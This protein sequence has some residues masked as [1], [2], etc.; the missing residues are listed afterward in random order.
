[1]KTIKYLATAILLCLTIAVSAQQNNTRTAY[2]LDGYTYGYRLNPAFA[3]KHNFVSIPVLGNVSLGAESNLA[4]SDFLYPSSNGKLALFIDD[5][6]S[7]QDFLGGLKDENKLNSNLNLTLLAVGFKTGNLY[8]TVDLS[9]KAGQNALLPKSLFSFVK[10]GTE[11]GDQSWNIGNTGIGLNAYG[12]LAYGLSTSIGESLRVGGRLKVILGLARAQMMIDQLDI[13]MSQE[14]W[15]ASTNG[16]IEYSG[17]VRFAVEGNNINLSSV[18]FGPF[19]GMSGFGLGVDLG[20]SYDF[21]DMFTA[22]VSLLDLGFTSWK[23]TTF[24][25]GGSSYEFD[26]FG[27]ISSGDELKDQLNGMTDELMDI[28]QFNK[29]GEGSASKG[30]SATLHAGLEARMPFYDRL[31]FGALA[32]HRFNGAYSWTEGRLAANVNPID[33]IGIAASYGISNFGSSLGG[34]VN[35]VFPGFNF[36]V[37]VDSFIPLMNVTPQFIPI[38]NLNTSLALGFNITFGK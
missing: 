31:S 26:G 16:T 35:F 7:A 19:D 10:I 14:K 30:L 21:L 38:D 32:T 22:S 4:L 11:N 28:I 15:T 9:V 3:P 8:H 27:T 1:M 24:A 20:A 33:C 37:G 17:P 18:E 23:N 36:F 34:I 25:K 5:S 12:E 13:A 29:T 2:F 6:V